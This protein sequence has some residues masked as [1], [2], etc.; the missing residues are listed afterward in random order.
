M[1]WKQN[2][3]IVQAEVGGSAGSKAVFI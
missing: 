3:L 2:I 1:F